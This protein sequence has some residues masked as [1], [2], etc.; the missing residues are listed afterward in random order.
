VGREREA[1]A[2]PSNAEESRS[3]VVSS[4]SGE[5]ALGGE[6]RREQTNL[7]ASDGSRAVF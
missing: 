3:L 6:E 7:G 2:P 5:E 4:E 1:E